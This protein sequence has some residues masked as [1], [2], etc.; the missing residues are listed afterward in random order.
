MIRQL[1]WCY[2]M[3]A[4]DGEN[5]QDPFFREAAY[6]TSLMLGIC[7]GNPMSMWFWWRASLLRRRRRRIARGWGG[8]SSSTYG[9]GDTAADLEGI[10]LVRRGER[11]QEE[12]FPVPGPLPDEHRGL[13]SLAVEFLFGTSKPPGPTEAD[14]WRLRSTVILEKSQ[15]SK[16]SSVPL[17]AMSPFLDSPPG[18]LEDVAKVVTE[19]LLVVA[20]FNGVPASDTK[21]DSLVKK[22]VDL[23]KAQ[24]VFPELLAES[25]HSTARY[26][27]PSIIHQVT[28]TFGAQ[29]TSRWAGLF[30]QK[31]ATHHSTPSNRTGGRTNS[32]PP[33]LNEQTIVFT[34]LTSKQF[35]HCLLVGILNWIGVIWFAQSLEI[36]GILEQFLAPGVVQALRWG[37]I[38]VL[39]F[40]A[41]LFFTIPFVRL[42]YILVWNEMC[43]R[44]N[45]RR[46]H[47]AAQ[48]AAEQPL[49]N[50][51]ITD[52]MKAN[53]RIA[54]VSQ[55]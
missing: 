3:F 36:G 48:L 15:Q 23:A 28:L 5:Q 55:V 22:E 26:D 51:D 18:S 49:A 14:R 19:G 29:A 39:R 50:D 4:P 25:S 35:Y 32:T 41:N 42:V 53:D 9:Y 6:D 17:Q 47:L 11:G 46:S 34:A 2:A 24:F 44:R 37:L 21:N 7:C 12:T 54:E 20:Y 40:Y 27:D 43:M 31:D 8:I 10:R 52:A 38:P 13:L 33:F 16:S 45:R 1:L 30:Y